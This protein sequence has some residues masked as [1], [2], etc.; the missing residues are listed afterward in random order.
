MESSRTLPLSTPGQQ[1]DGDRHLV[2]AGHWREPGARAS[3][4][5]KRACFESEYDQGYRCERHD[6]LGF[7]DE[8]AR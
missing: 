8:Q 2:D 6:T 3:A 4:T 5:T 1:P 7:P